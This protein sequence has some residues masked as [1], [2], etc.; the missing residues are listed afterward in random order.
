MFKNPFSFNGRIRR[1]EYVFSLMIAIVVFGFGNLIFSSIDIEGEIR[2]I[3]TI[4]SLVPLLW[5]IFSQGTKRC[6]DLT[7]DGFFQFLPFYN[8]SLIFTEGDYGENQYGKNP[9]N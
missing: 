9:K 1:L 2:E 5:F 8:L 7:K 3:I 4:M 6:H